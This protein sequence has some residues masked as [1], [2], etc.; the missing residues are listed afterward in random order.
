MKKYLLLISLTLLLAACHKREAAVVL[1]AITG[2]AQYLRIHDG[3]TYRQVDIL[4]PW[5]EGQLTARY[6]L[7]RHDSIATPQDGVR[8]HVPVERIATTSATQ[9]GFLHALGESGRIVGMTTPHLVYNRPTQA[10][11]DLGNDFDMNIEQLLLC[12]PDLLLMTRY[13]Q[14]MGN[15]TRLRQL[16][17]PM[18]ELVEWTEQ[19]P[20]ARAAWIRLFGA[21]TCREEAADSILRQVQSDY[22]ALAQAKDEH[23]KVTLMS[24]QSFQDTWYV[25][26]S[27]TYMGRLILDAGAQYAFATDTT[28]GS[29]PL[30]LE[31]ALI[32]FAEAEVWIGVNARSLAE[33]AAID[34]K[35]TWFASYQ[36][37]R[38][39]HFQHR[40]TDAGANDFWETG[41]VH[42]EYILE[43]IQNV[44]HP[45]AE[46]EYHFIEQLR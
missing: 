17:I 29:L 10:V 35:H 12:Q 32:A 19:D 44:L 16:G 26:T 38:V 11:Q 43:D 42:P 41:V 30:T 14:D 18:M 6:Y 33:L 15:V 5:Q 22:T 27:R 3:G 40:S 1:P 7:V 2:E 45:K 31:N 8:L 24:G 21:L 28:S 23:S 46:Y 39:Y 25:P 34:E 13:P 37:G 20:V 36:N 9:V 4:N